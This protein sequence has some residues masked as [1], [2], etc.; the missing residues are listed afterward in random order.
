MDCN[1]LSQFDE[2]MKTDGQIAFHLAQIQNLDL[3]FSGQYL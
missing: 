1:S 2:T 3:G